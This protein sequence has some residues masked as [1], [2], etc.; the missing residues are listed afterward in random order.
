MLNGIVNPFD[1]ITATD[2]LLHWAADNTDTYSLWTVD[3]A[4]AL[5]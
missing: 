1:I 4:S 5:V 2:W 3:S